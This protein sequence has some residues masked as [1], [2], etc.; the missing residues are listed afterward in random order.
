MLQSHKTQF[1]KY[2]KNQNFCVDVHKISVYNPFKFQFRQFAGGTCFSLSHGRSLS[3]TS[4]SAC[5]SEFFQRQE[6]A[7]ERDRFGHVCQENI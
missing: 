2:Q 6:M 4:L 7:G 3:V 1:L 5:M